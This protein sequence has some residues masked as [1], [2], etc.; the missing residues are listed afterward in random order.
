M[1]LPH[2]LLCLL[3]FSCQVSH[4]YPSS[5][6]RRLFQ[7]SSKKGI[8]CPPSFPE[9]P[10]YFASQETVHCAGQHGLAQ[11]WDP[12]AGLREH[13]GIEIPQQLCACNKTIFLEIDCLLSWRPK[14]SL[15]A[16]PVL[17]CLLVITVILRE[18]V[19]L[20]KKKKVEAGRHPKSFTNDSAWISYVNKEARLLHATFLFY[21]SSSETKLVLLICC[22]IFIQHLPSTSICIAGLCPLVA[23]NMA[24][25]IR[26]DKQIMPCT[27]NV[28][29]KLKFQYSSIKLYWSS[30]AHSFPP[31]LWLFSHSGTADK[32]TKWS[33]SLKCLLSDTLL[34][35]KLPTSL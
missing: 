30:H 12:V 25:E 13:Q 16:T 22:S 29:M 5:L 32:E 24:K 4:T 21:G 8:Y 26:R 11:P 18:I 28:K 23:Q 14:S 9:E 31:G 10:G 7:D 20:L 6:E 1:L 35:K 17:Q 3:T 2:I 27:R 15:L 34:K 33:Q 19:S